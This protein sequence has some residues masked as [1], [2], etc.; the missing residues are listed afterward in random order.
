MKKF[1]WAFLVGF[2]LL[3]FAQAEITDFPLGVTEMVWSLR[4]LG[5]AQ[6]LSLAVEGLPDGNYRVTL[7]LSLEGKGT[8]LSM[9]GFLGAPLSIAAMG[10]QIDLSTLN[11]IIRRR[12]VLNVGEKYALPGG[13]FYVREKA[14]IAGVL[15]LVGEF[16]PADRPD[17]VIEVG[18]SLA[19]PVYFLPLLRVNQGGRVT[20][21][22]VLTKYQR[23]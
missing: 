16:R 12:E 13:E 18:V 14:E 6:E 3:G 5:P 9:L 17:T 8:E 11:V 15:C 10:G 7:S 21:E 1:L 2:G 4:G 22:M 23:P 19:A 20:F